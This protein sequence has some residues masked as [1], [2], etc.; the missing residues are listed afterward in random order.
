[1]LRVAQT[2]QARLAILMDIS[3]AC[4]SQV[5]YGGARLTSPYRTGQ[6][7]CAALLVENGIPVV[8][9]RDFR[10][11]DK[12]L[13]KLDPT[14]APDLAARDHHESDWYVEYFKT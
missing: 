5:I 6:G 14:Y 1:M 9:Q 8:S 3:A 13:S 7:V 4:G 11:L 2:N 10:T 12:I